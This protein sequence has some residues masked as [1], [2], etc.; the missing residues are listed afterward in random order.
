MRSRVRT[1][2]LAVVFV[3]VVFA[4]AAPA[5]I[6]AF[7]QTASTSPS[8]TDIDVG[9]FDVSIGRPVT[10]PAAINTTSANE[11]HPSVTADGRYLVFERVD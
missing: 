11:F 7:A 10:L 4:P 6:F 1:C 9:L 3:L 5:D 2:S 8:R